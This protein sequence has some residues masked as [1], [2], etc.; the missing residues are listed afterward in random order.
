MAVSPDVVIGDRRSVDPE[1]LTKIQSLDLPTFGH[2]LKS[3]FVSGLTNLV[4]PKKI[5]VGTVF[6]VK[7]PTTDSRILHFAT[8]L[9]KPGDFVVIDTCLNNSLACLGGG[10]AYAL[11]SRGAA[12]VA[13]GGLATDLAELK[14][15][16]L[17]VYAR[18][19]TAITT[20]I[21]E[22]PIEG[23]INTPIQIG[24]V[25]AAPGMIA[26]ADSSGLLITEQHK[27]REQI[28]RVEELLRWESQMM[29]RVKAGGSLAE[30]I[31]NPA[32]LSEL[33]ALAQKEVKR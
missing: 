11:Q 3:G 9:I 19:L 7:V 33:R 18:G 25:I 22:G 20:R 13:V 14:D 31:L 29:P 16:G 26:I 5:A 28:D 1:L 12:G 17:C 8:E 30:E 27:V 23:E 15:S 6:T 32:D 4:T 21:G 10:V 24:G 2:I